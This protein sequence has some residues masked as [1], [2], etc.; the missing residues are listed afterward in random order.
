MFKTSTIKYH[1]E[2]KIKVI[3]NSTLW[4]KLQIKQN[5]IRTRLKIKLK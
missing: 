2:N 4:S 1:I 5:E 3:G